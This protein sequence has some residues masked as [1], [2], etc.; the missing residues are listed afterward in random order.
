MEITEYIL[1]QTL[2]DRGNYLECEEKGP[3][4]CNWENSWIGEGYYFWYHH[5]ELAIWWGN[6]KP[7]LKKTGF[8][9][10]KSV[11][12]NISKCWDLH[13]N[14]YHQEEFIKWLKKMKPSG[15]INDDTTVCQVLEF[16]KGESKEFIEKYEAI[17]ILGVDSL[18]KISANKFQ[19]PR[20]K[21]ETPK[22]DENASIQRFLAYYETVPPVQVCLFN[23]NSLS[24]EGFDVVFPDNYKKENRVFAEIFI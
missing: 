16:I 3:Y 14:P 21:F 24:R 12:S 13:A 7:N 4:P 18:S 5:L 1:F 10:F 19:M 6:V 9:V 22:E 11:C 23:Q 2:V 15:I 20:I 17:K 8:V